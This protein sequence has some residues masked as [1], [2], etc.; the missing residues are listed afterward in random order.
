MDDSGSFENDL[1]SEDDIMGF[2]DDDESFRSLGRRYHPMG[3]PRIQDPFLPGDLASVSAVG[4][5]LAGI[6][7]PQDPFGFV[8][9]EAPV[10]I[11]N[12]FLRSFQSSD[13]E[14][15]EEDEGFSEEA[16]SDEVL[17]R[18]SAFG[19]MSADDSSEERLAVNEDLL[20]SFYHNIDTQV[21]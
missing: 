8:P 10:Q 1:S 4:V 18:S 6:N 2:D 9:R 14:S 17:Y 15:G 7:G 21:D 11:N 19:L 16:D 12:P 3:I 13:G 5:P 20:G